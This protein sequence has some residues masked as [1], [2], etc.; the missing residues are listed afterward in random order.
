[1]N[2]VMADPQTHA[3]VGKA[4]E[5]HRNAKRELAA[6]KAN[7]AELA[8]LAA[9]LQHAL[10]NPSRIVFFDGTPIVGQGWLTLTDAL[11]QKL[12]AA[13][14]RKLAEDIKRVEKTKSAL[15]QRLFELEGEYPDSD[16][17]D[18]PPFIRAGRMNRR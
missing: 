5:D 15:R 6:L 4:R 17:D 2:I 7:A 18:R 16:D 14:V 1:M 9:Q 10:E 8:A 3:I 11:F 13:N 12:S